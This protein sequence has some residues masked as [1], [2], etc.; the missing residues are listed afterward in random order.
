M[1][2]STISIIEPIDA[3]TSDKK[4]FQTN[5]K[6][7][8]NTLLDIYKKEADYLKS[9]GSGNYGHLDELRSAY[10]IDDA[11]ATGEKYGYIFS[12]EVQYPGAGSPSRFFVTARPVNY[13]KTGKRSFYMNSS[14]EV[15]GEDKG[16][17]DAGMN[18]PVIQTCTPTISY[19]FE[20]EIKSVMRKLQSAQAI[21]FATAGKGTYGTI[22]D[23]HNAGLIDSPNPY[24]QNH[25]I[26]ISTTSLTAKTSV[27]FKIWAIPQIY[28]ETGIRSFYTDESG[29]LRGADK[30]G[31]YADKNDSIIEF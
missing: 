14:C 13:G 27:G 7:V 12:V 22:E 17:N 10:L 18:D 11:L 5:E 19:E 28:P 23:L 31:K 9:P 24:Y 3:K 20:N 4:A 6:L 26:K 29:L 21:Y 30:G 1:L 25:W 2:L 15:R 16:G 8:I